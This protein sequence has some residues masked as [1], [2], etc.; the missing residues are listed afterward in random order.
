MPSKL[1]EPKYYFDCS[2]FERELESVFKNLWLFG[3]LTTDIPNKNDY[4]VIEL[5]KHSII[6]YN[7]GNDIVALQNMCSHRFNRIFTEKRG[8]A[9]IICPF[10]SWGFDGCGVIRNKKIAYTDDLCEQLSLKR[11]CIDIVGKFI[12]YN[13][14][15]NPPQTLIGQLGGIEKELIEVSEILDSKIHEEYINHKVNWKFICENVVD[16]THCTSLH[17]ETL[18]KIGYCIEPNVST[19][20]YGNNSLV[21]LPP[22]QN[23][24]RLKRNKLLNRFLPRK[25]ENNLYKHI[26]IFPNLTLG[27]YDGLNI[28]IGS[29]IP[30]NANETSYKLDYYLA[31]VY[32]KSEVSKSF[33]KVMIDDVISFGARIFDEDKVILEQVQ[34]GVKEADHLGYVYDDEVRIKNFYNAYLNC[35]NK[36]GKF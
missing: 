20:L 7:N 29:I 11:Y 14:E 2:H 8:N 34:K 31:E 17:Q 25:F 26:L 28:A 18:V 3:C 27:I 24:E 1:I 9:P 10:H 35:I 23:K 4:Y 16:K 36:N 30:I 21:I 15:C 22:I 5:G 13:F 19:E 32:S 33:L 6:I 12:F